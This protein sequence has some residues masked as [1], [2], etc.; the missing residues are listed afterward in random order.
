MVKRSNILLE[1]CFSAALF[2]PS[3][4]GGVESPVEVQAT[5]PA[6]RQAPV[7]VVNVHSPVRPH[8]PPGFPRK[9]VHGPVPS[10]CGLVFCYVAKVALGII[11]DV[12]GDLWSC[13]I[14]LF[15]MLHTS[16]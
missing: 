6:L 10:Q 9:R 5:V 15:P 7:E 14:I 1:F 3:Y 16:L 2:G 13:E 12:P 8:G 11:S 4:T